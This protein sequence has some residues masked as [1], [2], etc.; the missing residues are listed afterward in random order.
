MSRATAVY[1]VTFVSLVAGLWVVLRLGAAL[2][3]QPDLSGTWELEN[4][5]SVGGWPPFGRALRVEQSGLFVRFVFDEG[6]ALD[7]KVA[8]RRLE[9]RGGERVPVIELRDDAAPVV[10]AVGDPDTGRLRLRFAGA[11]DVAE[12]PAVRTARPHAT[13]GGGAHAPR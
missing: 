7:L 5:V 6:P 8:A 9:Q 2:Q 4:D 13:P 1:V 11:S 10:E 12:T 3:A